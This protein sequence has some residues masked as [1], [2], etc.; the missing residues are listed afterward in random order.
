M[1]ERGYTLLEVVAVL[2]LLSLL[3]AGV[4]PLLTTGEQAYDEAR[5]QEMQRNLRVALDR[6]MREVRAAQAV[7]EAQNGL[8]VLDPITEYDGDAGT[9]QPTVEFVLNPGTGDLEYRWRSNWDYRRRVTVLA[10]MGVTIP[11][12]YSVAVCLDH[13]TLVSNGKSQPDGSDVRIRFFDGRRMLELDRF[14]DPASA[15]NGTNNLSGCSPTQV[16]LWFRLQRPIPAGEKDEQYFVYYGNPA[17]GPAPANPDHVFLDYEDGRGLEGWTRRD[18]R[19]G[20]YTPTSDGFHFSASLG[21]GFREF[22]RALPHDNV[23]MLWRFR[24]DSD[25]NDGT[26]DG[27]QVGVGV[28]LSDSGAGYRL[29]L[30]GGTDNTGGGTGNNCL[31]LHYWTGWAGDGRVLGSG[32]VC[33]EPGVEYYARFA[34]VGHWLRAKVWRVGIQD[35]GP[36]SWDIR[37]D[38]SNTDYTDSRRFSGE[39]I[40]LVNGERTPMIHWHRFVWVRLR[41][42]PE[43]A[44]SLGSEESGV[45]TDPLVTLSGPFSGMTVQYDQSV[46]QVEVELV[47]HDRE[48]RVPDLAARA[49]AV[50]RTP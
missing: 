25:T 10:P 45:R 26:N 11:A 24:S 42:E 40:S 37:Y 32:G 18:T 35:P 14:L 49:R 17:A 3:V 44:T 21:T 47:A 34:L 39:H 7:R 28:R 22:S 19:P 31:R 20:T 8:L 6:I 36:G 29:T 41:T 13:A 1:K 38:I 12:G 46:R 33:I 5:R 15:W 16:K 48:N 4:L 2:L 30:G 23:E 43:P 27:R 9:D 50:L